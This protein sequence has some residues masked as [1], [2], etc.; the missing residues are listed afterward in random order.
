MAG[1][2]RR[3]SNCVFGE[4]FGANLVGFNDAIADALA[5]R[6]T[7][8]MM[9]A[10][11]LA[12][13]YYQEDPDNRDRWWTTQRQKILDGLAGVGIGNPDEYVASYLKSYRDRM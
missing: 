10:Y 2:Y 6:G 3:F 13:A 9:A 4:L 5:S 11:V 1:L 7:Q 8:R 12:E